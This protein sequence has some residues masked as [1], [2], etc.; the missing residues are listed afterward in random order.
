MMEQYYKQFFPHYDAPTTGT[1]GMP[2]HGLRVSQN[3][4]QRQQAG[5]QAGWVMP[6]GA[7]KPPSDP[8]SADYAA[9]YYQYYY[10]AAAAFA[11]SW[12]QA[13]GEDPT[14]GR[15]TP[16]IFIEPHLRASLQSPG[17]LI[18]ILPNR[19]QD[20]EPGRVEFLDLG[21]LATDVVAEATTRLAEVSVSSAVGQ[22]QLTDSG[23]GS[24]TT[25]AEGSFGQSLSASREDTSDAHSYSLQNTEGDEEE[26]DV[27]ECT[28]IITGWDRTDH[29]LYPGPLT[30]N[31]TLKS[32]VLAFLRGKLEDIQDRMP[33]DWDSAGLLLSYLELLVKNNGVVHPGDVVSLLL[34]NQSS[35][36]YEYSVSGAPSAAF[37]VASG[38]RM[39]KRV[40][41]DAFFYY[42]P[43]HHS[44][45]ELSSLPPSE[46][47]S[48]RESPSLKHSASSGYFQQQQQQHH[49][50]RSTAGSSVS[51]ASV[52]RL[53]R[54]AAAAAATIGAPGI[55]TED[56]ELLAV[57]RFREVGYFHPR[58]SPQCFLLASPPHDAPSFFTHTPVKL[59]LHGHLV[60]ALEH[61]C[62]QQLW[63]HAFALAQRLGPGM[64]SKVMDRFLG[65]AVRPT[66]PLLTF[67]QLTAGQLPLAVDQLAYVTGECLSA[68]CRNGRFSFSSSPLH[69]GLLGADNGDWRPHLAM[70]LSAPE[71]QIS[72]ARDAIE[73]MGESLFARRLVYAAHFCFLLLS[74]FRG[75]TPSASPSTAA[76]LLS[77]RIWLLGVVRPTESDAEAGPQSIVEADGD[78]GAV[79]QLN[80][81]EQA[82]N[83]AFQ[84][85]EVY[86]FTLALASRER[87]LFLPQLLLYIIRAGSLLSCPYTPPLNCIFCLQPIKFVYCMRLIDAGL[88][89]KAFRY[90]EVLSY[91]LVAAFQSDS[92]V[93]QASLFVMI[94]QCLQFAERLRYHPGIDSFESAMDGGRCGLG[95][96]DPR[97]TRLFVWIDRLR[98]VY[99]RL[100]G[101]LGLPTEQSPLVDPPAEHQ[102]QRD[103]ADQRS[104]PV[105]QYPQ[106][107]LIDDPHATPPGPPHAPDQHS[108]TYTAVAHAPLGHAYDPGHSQH[109]PAHRSER[110]KESHQCPDTSQPTV[111]VSHTQSLPSASPAG[112]M[113]GTVVKNDITDGS[114]NRSSDAPLQ[115]HRQHQQFQHQYCNPSNDNAATTNST[116]SVSTSGAAS[117]VVP[118][119]QQQQHLLA[120]PTGAL[121]VGQHPVAGRSLLFQPSSQP[122]DTTPT[123]P[124]QYDYFAHYS[125]VSARSRNISASSHG[126]AAPEDLT[127]R[128]SN[129]GHAAPY[130]AAPPKMATSLCLGMAENSIQE[131]PPPP[132]GRRPDSNPSDFTRPLSHLGRLS[133][134]SSVEGDEEEEEDDD[135]DDLTH[136]IASRPSP[137]SFYAY[138]QPPV[139]RG[140]VRPSAAPPVAGQQL[141]TP[142][143]PP[144][145][146]KRPAP[147]V[148]G[149][150]QQPLV[151][152]GS[153]PI[154]E[155]QMVEDSPQHQPVHA[156]RGVEKKCQPSGGAKE[157]STSAKE[158][159]VEDSDDPSTAASAAPPRANSKIIWDDQAKRWIDVNNPEPEELPPPPPVLPNPTSVD[160][161]VVSAAAANEPPR[162]P[163]GAPNATRSVRSPAGRPRYV[164]VLANQTSGSAAQKVG[165][166]HLAP[167]LPP[168]L[169]SS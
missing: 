25:Q 89:A 156:N 79:R 126:S 39:H 16:K 127:G 43:P 61:A 56:R 93:D 76:T 45:A 102:Q 124:A 80:Y 14:A 62:Q 159:N 113:T 71:A 30:L 38:Q 46:P 42:P 10:G 20:N 81:A 33:V 54:K 161:P 85:T 63:G 96:T 9:L 57:N 37:G 154:S 131:V 109:W 97:T 18:Q 86:E 142:V 114:A 29:A 34:E 143:P 73:R 3:P 48:G 128:T 51:G 64:L 26:E 121:D 91:S 52:S 137:H 67:Y 168:V 155:M 98:E 141:N 107:P 90:L 140:F 138:H 169:S 17:L 59:L 100:C 117:Y 60:K 27:K 28:A 129:G 88:I 21:Q 123:E 4:P 31:S 44:S 116:L 106:Q 125:Q 5:P 50:R 12:L 87:C 1:K 104:T 74:A 95:T 162:V 130:L 108:Q 122:Q 22:H 11:Q 120:P 99:D 157:D 7:Q 148:F 115:S 163:M 69:P 150:N 68:L 111:V 133:S 94:S 41:S 65:K 15:H 53:L 145:S 146:V 83:E 75:P 40:S 112:G 134:G 160:V 92:G 105:P 136:Q 70:L 165:V 36:H 164:N 77:S 147:F 158:G 82:P 132:V 153:P 2:G 47:T 103:T 19:P 144:V 23:R 166:N 101:E 72:L 152:P 8:S 139:T 66:D 55:S 167:P 49:S 58:F 35:H 6:P 78:S 13:G 135:D 24:R 149:S 119:T 110:A 84:L 118:P 151:P 32:D